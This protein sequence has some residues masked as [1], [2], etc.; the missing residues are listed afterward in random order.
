MYAYEGVL[1]GRVIDVLKN[2]AKVRLFSSP[3]ETHQVLIGSNSIPATAIG[4][5][6][7]QYEA[8]VS[9]DVQIMEG[10][11]VINPSLND[12]PFGIVSVVL[13]NPTE[14]FSTVLFAPPISVYQLKWVLVKD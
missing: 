13:S 3:G 8:E 2:S 7:G 4:R 1:V 11:F 12:R 10:D 6:G 9:R 5:G 14:P